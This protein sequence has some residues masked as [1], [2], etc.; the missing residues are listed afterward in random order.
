MRKT[1]AIASHRRQRGAVLYVAL[2]MLVLISLLGI[3][4]IQVSGL[5]ERMAANYRNTNLAFQNAEDSVSTAECYLDSV[6]NR[7]APG[8]CTPA[9]T[10]IETICET[11]F[12]A[13]GWAWKRAM[14]SAP[15]DSVSMRSIG[16]CVSGQSGIGMGREA[17]RGG[18]PNPIYQVTVYATDL[19]NN[20]TADAAI[21]TVF[22]P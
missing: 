8:A 2:I 5:Q 18:D 12:D 14:A 9:S 22:M 20:P 11:D 17:E 6:V 19:A 3:A 13:T 10:E 15:A 16:Q 1:S 4:A 21:D 7:R